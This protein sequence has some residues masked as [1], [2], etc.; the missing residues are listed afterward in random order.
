MQ[1]SH[2]HLTPDRVNGTVQDIS[3]PGTPTNDDVMNMSHISSQN[4][5][6]TPHGCSPHINNHL[7]PV[8]PHLVIPAAGHTPLLSPN[9]LLNSANLSTAT[10]LHPLQQALLMQQQLPAQILT[11]V[12]Q[13]MTFSKQN[14]SFEA[15]IR[16][17]KS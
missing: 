17:N 2:Q 14:S 3:P 16:L 13:F 11:Q 4:Q 12:L 7:T 1:R 8:A 9:L 15:M 5:P 10:L 6:F